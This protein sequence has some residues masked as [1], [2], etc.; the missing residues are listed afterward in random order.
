MNRRFFGW[1]LA[2]VCLM[3]V[4]AVDGG[5]FNRVVDLGATLPE[6]GP[7]PATDGS[8]LSAADLSE[9]VVVLVFLAN[10]CPW[11]RGMD[12]DLVALVDGFAGRSVRFVGVGVNRIEEDRLPAMKEH[13][14]A[15][16]YDFTYVYDDSQELGRQLGATRTPEYFVFDGDRKLAYMGAI[17]N[18]PASQRGDGS[19]H[20]TNGEPTEFYVR[21]AVKALLTG[22]EVPV[23]E[24][25]A[26]GCTVKYEGERGGVRGGGRSWALALLALWLLSGASA[27]AEDRVAEGWRRCG[28][29][30][31]FVRRLDRTA[32]SAAWPDRG[33]GPVGD[34]VQAVPGGVPAPGGAC[35]A[36]RASRG[37][38]P[39]A[40]PGR[41][42][43]RA[44]THIR[45]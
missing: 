10:H 1:V 39:L 30:T 41:S 40:F 6:F 2:T 27:Y 22:G 19:I 11:V 36:L 8:E 42:G 45:S 3:V 17:H 32:R 14:E 28:V 4:P 31:G 33:G 34:L 21:D 12:A 15:N 16:G 38:V 37:G 44:G 7:L 24:T 5:E 9:E 23:G 26:H 25:R 20:Y 43:R 35:R 18:S 13:A 29:G